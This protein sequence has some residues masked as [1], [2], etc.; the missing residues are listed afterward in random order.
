MRPNLHALFSQLLRARRVTACGL[1][2][3][4]GA[5][6][7]GC[8]NTDTDGTGGTGGTDAVTDTATGTDD[9]S[10]DGS[11]TGTDLG[12]AADGADA[13]GT[14]DATGGDDAADAAGGDGTTVDVKVGDAKGGD[15]AGGD[16]YA[17]LLIKILNP[18]GREWGQSEGAAT[19]L[20]GVAF[21]EPDTIAW[22]LASGPSGVICGAPPAAMTCDVYRKTDNNGDFWQ[23]DIV[24]LAQGDNSV[25]VTATKGT[26]SVSDAVHITYN[27]LFSFDGPPLI[28]PNAIFVGEN[29]TLVVGMSIPNASKSDVVDASTITLIEVDEDGKELKS[30]TTL[31]DDGNGGNCDDQ[32]QDSVFSTC[33]PLTPNAPKVYRFRVKVKISVV[34]SGTTKTEYYALSP[35]TEVDAVNHFT[36]SECNAIKGLQTKIRDGFQS[37]VAGGQAPDAAVAAALAAAK[38]DA[39]VA[40]A[41]TSDIGNVWIRYKSGRLGAVNLMGADVRAGGGGPDEGSA[42]IPTYS[43]GTRRALS[44]APFATSFKATGDEA[45]DAAKALNAKQCPPFATDAYA[46]GAAY[47][48]YYRE[49]SQYGIVA[50]TGHGDALFAGMDTAAKQALRWEHLGSQETIWSGEAVDCGAISATSGTCAQNGSGCKPTETCV[51]TSKEAG[52]C[53]DHTQ[54]DVMSGRAIIG[55]STYGFVPSFVRH[56]SPDKF[57]ASIVYLGTC[58]SMYTG[59]LA[60]QYIAAG[61][62]AVVGFSDY[63]G[64]QFAYTDG[65][66]LFDN[67]INQGNSVLQGLTLADDPAHPGSHMRLFGESKANAK[68]ANLINPSWDLGRVT[69]WKAV[70]DGRVISR[71]GATLPVAGKYMGIISTG[72]GFTTTNGSLEQ[73]FCV[74]KNKSSLCYFWKFYSEE[75]TEFCGSQFMDRFTST[76]TADSGKITMTDAWIDQLCPYDCG[77]KSPCEPGSPSCKCGQQWKTLTPADVSFDV[78]NVWMTPWQKECTD[79]SGLSGADKKVTLKFFATDTGDSIYDTVILLDEVTVD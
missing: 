61:A 24:T 38:A 43:V 55:D 70:G 50:I 39:S 74:D 30:Y 58:R 17:E 40:E 37:S 62:A 5:L 16:H 51:K 36:Q 77:G 54:A 31:K 18:T 8:G 52:V 29:A 23:S 14:D 26:A 22:S 49:S 13:T 45:V 56:H 41:G 33:L 4:A 10:A 47:L 53:V 9:A 46:D 48:R 2:L 59:A 27:P 69:G 32:Q 35:V 3:V 11:D 1:W 65:S 6:V 60:L 28:S 15:S 79:V 73:P 12:D 57:P 21:G 78:G 19:T 44:L 20:A 71:L 64:Q 67:L 63:V 25:T 42:A 7:V 68:D 66:T 72:L 76:L 34:L 75:F